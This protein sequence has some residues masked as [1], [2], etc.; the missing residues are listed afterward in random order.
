MLRADSAKIDW[1]PSKKHWQVQ[2]HVGAEVIKR[3]FPKLP[4]SADEESLRSAAIATAK[5]EGY[6]LDPSRVQIAVRGAAGG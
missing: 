3:S 5:D 1:D 2:I 6:D 4:E